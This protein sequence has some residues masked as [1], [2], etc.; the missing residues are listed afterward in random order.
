MKIRVSTH[1]EQRMRERLGLNKKSIERI[2]QRAFDNGI[3]HN[4][5]K[6]NLRKYVTHVWEKNKNANNIRI[7]GDKVFVFCDELLVT[8]FHLPHD[9]AR[10]M[11]YLVKNE[12]K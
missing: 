3:R 12:R 2:A 10:E 6:G 8:V 9:L 5:T 11:D 1:A 4:Q 7:Y